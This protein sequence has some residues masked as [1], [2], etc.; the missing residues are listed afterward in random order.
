M[1]TRR[2]IFIWAAVTLLGGLTTAFP[3]GA[4]AVGDSSADLS[5][6]QVATNAAGEGIDGT[7][8]ELF[9]G[10]VVTYTVTVTNQGP[11]NAESVTATETAPAQIDSA[12][13]QSCDP[14][15]ADCSALANFTDYASGTSLSL[16]TIAASASKDLVFRG[17]VKSATLPRDITNVVSATSAQTDPDTTNN[18]D[19]ALVTPVDTLG[20]ISVSQAAK[21]SAGKAIDKTNRVRAG[22]IVTYVATIENA[23]PSDARNV[24][25]KNTFDSGVTNQLSCVGSCSASSAFSSYQ[26]SSLLSLGPLAAGATKAVSFRGTLPTTISA[27]TDITNVVSVKSYKTGTVG[28]TA[29]SDTADSTSTI[30]TTVYKAK[31][32]KSSSANSSTNS[33]SLSSGP[34]TGVYFGKIGE[35]TY[36][37]PLQRTKTVVIKKVYYQSAYG[38][39]IPEAASAP[40]VESATQTVIAPV[41]STIVRMPEEVWLV[42]PVG[43]L[44]IIWITYLVL[45]P[46]E[47]QLLGAARTPPS[48]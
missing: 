4:I 12:T 43:L 11:S 42:L 1:T 16:G 9:A 24:K 17:E 6:A 20:D 23:G 26:S 18:T 22:D 31:S 39:R 28:A 37:E 3:L 27:T 29:D 2:R 36:F 46:Y 30:T 13:L 35:P 8:S 5:V 7:T 32:Q 41:A 19:V 10:Q 21:N 15:A 40:L 47:D 25:V 14:Q 48:V 38:R 45:E 44:L 34:S 33:S